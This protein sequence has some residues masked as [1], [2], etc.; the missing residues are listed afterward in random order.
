MSDFHERDADDRLV[1]LLREAGRAAVPPAASADLAGRVRRRHARRTRPRRVAGGAA[2]ALVLIAAGGAL[3]AAWRSGNGQSPEV[4]TQAEPATS[5]ADAAEIA[6][7]R[8]EIERLEAEA[9]RLAEVIRQNERREQLNRRLAALRR[10]AGGLDGR[11]LALVEFE[12]TAFLLIHRADSRAPDDRA[13]AY[14]QA[15]ELFPETTWG[16]TARERLNKICREKQ[17]ETHD[18]IP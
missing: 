12:K 1:Q 17:K 18:A 15:A 6:R 10:E 7:L 9:Q 13:A 5:D 11:E 14:R 3:V 16:Q 4:A 8:T 2:A